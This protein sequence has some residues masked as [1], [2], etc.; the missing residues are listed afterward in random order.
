MSNDWE[1]FLAAHGEDIQSSVTESLI[2]NAHLFDINDGTHASW[3]DNQLGILVVFTEDEAEHLAS[4]EWRLKEGFASMPAFR[5]F[6]GRMLEDLTARAVESR[7]G[8]PMEA[9]E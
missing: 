1:A 2:K 9:E 6:L 3:Y 5:E 4:E 8:D 7:F